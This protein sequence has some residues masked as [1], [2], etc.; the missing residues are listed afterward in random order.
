MTRILRPAGRAR[1]RGDHHLRQ[2]AA[3][4]RPGRPVRRRRRDPRRAD[5]RAGVLPAGHTVRP[6]GHP[7][8][9][10]DRMVAGVDAEHGRRGRSVRGALRGRPRRRATGL[11]VPDHRRTSGLKA[12]V[13]A[14]CAAGAMPRRAGRRPLDRPPRCRRGRRA[15]RARAAR[16]DPLRRPRGRR[17][18]GAAPLARDPHAPAGR[19]GIAHA[20]STSC[21]SACA[22]TGRPVGLRMGSAARLSVAS[23]GRDRRAWDG[24]GDGRRARRVGRRPARVPLRRH[25]R[26]RSRLRA[27]HRHARAG[28]AT[29]ARELLRAVRRIATEVPLAGME[30]VEVSPPYDHAEITALLAHRVVL[31]ALSGHGA[32]EARPRPG[33][34][35]VELTWPRSCGSASASRRSFRT[36]G[37]TSRPC[38]GSSSAWSVSATTAHGC[39]SSRSARPG[40]STRLALLAYAAA[41][42]ERIRLGTAVILLPLRVPVELAKTLASLDQL[43]EGRL[44]AGVALGGK[45][46]VPGVRAH[47]GPSPA[48]RGGGRVD[49][50]PLDRGPTVTLDGEFWHLDRRAVEPK[51]VQQPHPPLWFGG[52][53]RPGGTSA[54]PG[55]PTA[56]SARGRS[57]P[58]TS[59]PRTRPGGGPGGGGPRPSRLPRRQARVRRGGRRPRPRR[60]AAGRVVPAP[61]T[62][63][64]SWPSASPSSGRRRR[65]WSSWRRW[66]VAGPSSSCSTPCSTRKHRPRSLRQR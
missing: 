59:S 50:A 37:R 64:P 42:T 57:A 23:D 7:R 52:T 61:S 18:R 26:V 15:R 16:T 62:A 32:S 46:R 9:G 51:P 25:R 20:A 14:V 54:R 2:A 21:R 30:V 65:A 56:G 3:G 58:R 53:A 43:S 19:G 55:S 8:G 4:A 38:G 66:R 12:A 11:R 34:R 36:P 33:A 10:P 44:I 13:S 47:R 35:T 27:R 1:L 40:R 39:S 22:A 5:R 29:T 24:P 60:R 28:R 48:V 45:D 31:E 63:A 41:V 6:P 17:V 49:E